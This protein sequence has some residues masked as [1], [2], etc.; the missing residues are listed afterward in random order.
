MTVLAAR[1]PV[2]SPLAIAA[3][4]VADFAA[5]SLIVRRPENAGG[6]EKLLWREAHGQLVKAEELGWPGGTPLVWASAP[7][8]YQFARV[9]PGPNLTLLVGFVPG[10]ENARIYAE[11]VGRPDLSA[12]V[13]A[14]K[15]LRR[16]LG[17]TF[18]YSR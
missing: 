9:T 3:P 1:T 16:F 13:T 6:T 2:P 18:R 5:M 10:T 17:V 14:D 11:L 7:G 4:A 8:H 12:F 15:S